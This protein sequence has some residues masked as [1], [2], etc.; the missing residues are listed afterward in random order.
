M[1]NAILIAEDDENIRNALVD[2]LTSENYAVTAVADG[3]AA[4]ATWLEKGDSFRLLLLDIMMPGKSGYDV[5]RIVRETDTRIPIIMLSA[6]SEEVDKVL[7]LN[8][9]ADDYITKPFGVQELLARI[10]A[11]VRRTDAQRQD[12]LGL[13]RKD[14]KISGATVSVREYAL[15]SGEQRI[16]LTDR[17]INLLEFLAHHKGEVLGRDKIL[18]ELWGIEYLGTTRTLDQHIA[19][20]R[21]KLVTVIGRDPIQTI[22][23]VGYR[24]V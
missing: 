23:G 20:L 13:A 22:H 4:I 10:A 2:I 15:E 12:N 1:N 8:L 11:V 24:L 19:Q 3:N 21:K 16:P 14:F 9:G 7:G 6:K 17:E 5:C 18:N